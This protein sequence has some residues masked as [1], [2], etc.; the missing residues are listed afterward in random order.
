MGYQNVA[1]GGNHRCP[2]Y[3]E[4]IN[5]RVDEVRISDIARYA[6]SFEPPRREFDPD[7]HTLLLMHFTAGGEN[8]GL[9]GDDVIPSEFLSVVSCAAT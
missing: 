8:V 3:Y 9:I 4:V 5:G 2:G 7:P 6:G 1:I